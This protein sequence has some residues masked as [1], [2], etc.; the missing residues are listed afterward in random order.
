MSVFCLKQSHEGHVGAD[1]FLDAILKV[2]E[3]ASPPHILVA[4]YVHSA[5]VIYGCVGHHYVLQSSHP[6]K[7]PEFL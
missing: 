1:I 3:N 5:A 7:C 6:G 4:L 2:S